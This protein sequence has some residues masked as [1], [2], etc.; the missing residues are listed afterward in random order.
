MRSMIS[1]ETRAKI[2]AALTDVA[3]RHHIGLTPSTLDR[4]APFRVTAMKVRDEHDAEVRALES[5]ALA[6][7]ARKH[8]RLARAEFLPKV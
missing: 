8:S 6:N 7:L 1:P 2:E 5:L 4:R 3:A